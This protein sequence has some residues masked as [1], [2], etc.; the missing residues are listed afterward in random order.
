MGTEGIMSYSTTPDLHFTAS[1]VDNICK[2]LDLAV[3]AAWSC[4]EPAQSVCGN[5]VLEP[6]EQCD[7]STSCCTDCTYTHQC[8][9]EDNECC[10]HSCSFQPGTQ[11]CGF[12]K[13]Y[14]TAGRCAANSVC[15]TC[16]NIVPC[17]PSTSYDDGCVQLCRYSDGT[18]CYPAHW[19]GAGINATQ[20][21]VEDGTVCSESPVKTCQKGACE[22]PQ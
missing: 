21:R 13:R 4:F 15:D 10:T 5:G 7:D 19:F 22:A 16:T 2:E 18:T 3:H 6:G 14:C 20:A 12:G 9:P 1:N 17:P 11:A 8:T